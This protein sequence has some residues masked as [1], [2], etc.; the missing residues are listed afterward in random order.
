[1]RKKRREKEEK[2][3]TCLR[4]WGLYAWIGLRGRGRVLSAI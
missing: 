3:Q 1:M 2:G 4:G